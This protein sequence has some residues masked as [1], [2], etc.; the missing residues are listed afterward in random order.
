MKAKGNSVTKTA[1]WILMGMLILGLG[2]FGAVNFNGNVSSIG[3]VGDKEIS[4]DQYARELQQQIRAIEGQTGE[5]LSFQQ[6]QA[7]GLDRAV[8]Q[9]IVRL[10]ALDNE[11]TEMGISLGD[12]NLRE[13]IIDIPARL[14]E[15]NVRSVSEGKDAQ[16]DVR[17]TITVSGRQYSG[18]GV[19][20][21][22]IEAAAIA[23]L[24][25]LNKADA[26]RQSGV[27]AADGQPIAESP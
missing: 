1:V 22:I 26:D 13:R 9:R 4:V 8:L 21:D 6:A 3:T 15:F 17:V 12:E 7:I 2:G 5:A 23:Y 24:K 18:K 11:T 10:R 14:E 20:T 19:S 27:S 16:G 25:A